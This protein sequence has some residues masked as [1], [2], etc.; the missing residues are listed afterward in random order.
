[1]PW[2]LDQFFF[3]G[4]EVQ[5]YKGPEGKGKFEQRPITKKSRANALDYK[6][7]LLSVFLVKTFTY[8]INVT[9][10]HT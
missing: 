1:M 7:T 9:F 10:F 4:P 3:R 6:S 5:R 2:T 8:E